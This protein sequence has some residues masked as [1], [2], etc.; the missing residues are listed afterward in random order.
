MGSMIFED[1]QMATLRCLI[2]AHSVV[3]PQSFAKEYALDE[4][5]KVATLVWSYAH[6]YVNGNPVSSAALGNVQR[7]SNGNT[8]INWGWIPYNSGF[9]NVTEVDR[10]KHYL[11][12]AMRSLQLE[13]HL[14]RI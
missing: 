9:P 8:L 5:N 3:P 10:R 7:L 4:I 2:M 1:W 13:Y 6:P 12:N 11:G 14:S